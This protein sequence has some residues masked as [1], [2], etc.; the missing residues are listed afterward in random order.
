MRKPKLIRKKLFTWAN[1]SLSL[2]NLQ[3]NVKH[4]KGRINNQILE[5][6][7]L[8]CAT[9]VMEDGEFNRKIYIKVEAVATDQFRYK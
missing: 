2:A 9:P 1:I 5:V 7:G 3:G 8:T 6:K 4:L